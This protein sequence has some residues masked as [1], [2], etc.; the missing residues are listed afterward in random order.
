MLGQRPFHTQDTYNNVYKLGAEEQKN[1]F[2]IGLYH[3][4]IGGSH[5]PSFSG[6]VQVHQCKEGDVRELLK[7]NP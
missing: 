7:Q 5:T 3:K 1:Q 2:S 4:L 6:F